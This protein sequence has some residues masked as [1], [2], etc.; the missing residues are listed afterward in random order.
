M[1][2]NRGCGGSPPIRAAAGCGDAPCIRGECPKPPN[3][4]AAMAAML[5]IKGSLASGKGGG[6]RLRD[7]EAA[8][9]EVAP[10][11]GGG[12]RLD[13]LLFIWPLTMMH[14]QLTLQFH[15]DETMSLLQ[16]IIH[17]FLICK[18]VRLLVTCEKRQMR[19]ASN[20]PRSKICCT[21]KRRKHC[22][23]RN[24]EGGIL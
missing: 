6:G 12:D 20:S 1:P 8:G 10:A 16:H 17:T 5:N 24:E 15:Y 18:Y 22:M 19:N 13:G 21:R 14:G 9:V 11:G 2:K 23:K 4:A 3:P 7:V